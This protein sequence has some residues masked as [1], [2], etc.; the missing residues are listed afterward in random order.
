MHIVPTGD[1]L[2]ISFIFC[3]PRPNL[4]IPVLCLKGQTWEWNYT[5]KKNGL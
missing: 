5:E 4:F 1:S 2:F 3:M